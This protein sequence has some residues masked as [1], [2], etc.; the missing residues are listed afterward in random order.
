VSFSPAMSTKAIKAKGQ[1]IRSWHLNRRTGKHLSGL[2]EAINPQVRGWIN[3]YGPSTAPSCTHCTT[4]RRAPRPVGHVQVQRLRGSPRRAWEW[5]AAVRERVRSCSPT[6]RLPD[7]RQSTCGSRMT[8]DCHVRFY[9]S[10][11]G[12]SSRHSPDAVTVASGDPPSAHPSYT[13]CWDSTHGPSRCQAVGR[14]CRL[15]GQAEL[16][17]FPRARAPKSSPWPRWPKKCAGAAR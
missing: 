4:H 13:T 10:G 2:A 15:P 3:Y 9:E 7:H 14:P 12:S 5:L 1:Q 17:W 16:D 8:G 11:R 6:G